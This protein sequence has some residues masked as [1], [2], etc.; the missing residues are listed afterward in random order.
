[1]L[2]QLHHKRDRKRRDRT[3]L[4]Q[5]LPTTLNPKMKLLRFHDNVRPAYWGTFSKTSK[6]I[7]G[8]K[9][10]SMDEEMFDYEVDSD[11]EWEEEGEGEVL[12]DT[13]DKKDCDEEDEDEEEDEEVV[14]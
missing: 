8:K 4:L 14:C 3:S 5:G 13:E 7:S 10:L 11:G 12:S 6:K 9:P 2:A 1:M